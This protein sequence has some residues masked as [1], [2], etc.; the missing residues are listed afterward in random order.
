[1]AVTSGANMNF[2]QLPEIVER[3]NLAGT[4]SL[5]VTKL[6]EKPGSLKA[7]AD[8]VCSFCSYSNNNNKNKT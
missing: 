4:E 5:L 6:P 3:A 7:L 2:D 8:L 1:M